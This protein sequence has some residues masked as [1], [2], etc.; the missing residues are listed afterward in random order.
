MSEWF[1]FW[2]R[3][4]ESL[5]TSL[6]LGHQLRFTHSLL[7]LHTKISITDTA[8]AHIA[9]NLLFYIPG[10]GQ[11]GWMQMVQIVWLDANSELL[12]YSRL[13]A[14][15]SVLLRLPTAPPRLA[16]TLRLHQVLRRHFVQKYHCWLGKEPFTLRNA[17]NCPCSPRHPS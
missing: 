6:T 1:F 13:G 16:S 12:R 14:R 9:K 10:S 7:L 17:N 5:A 11:R 8:C 2:R 3:L 15:N 4:Y